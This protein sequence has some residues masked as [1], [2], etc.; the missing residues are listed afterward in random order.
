MRKILLGLTIILLTSTLAL[1]QEITTTKTIKGFFKE[2]T[3]LRVAQEAAEIY[4]AA[5]NE[6]SL[7]VIQKATTLAKEDGRKTVLK[8]DIDQATED[9]FRRAPMTVA[10]LLEKIG[11]LSTIELTE[12]TNQV[13]AYS[14][15][16]LEKKE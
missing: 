10:E 12:L 14:E 2:N 7:Q 16:L 3:D 13:K 5:L 4:K 1:A 8:R 11:Q 9:V 15:E 6:M